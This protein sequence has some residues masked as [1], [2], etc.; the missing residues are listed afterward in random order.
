MDEE[1]R[2]LEKTFSDLSLCLSYVTALYNAGELRGIDAKMFTKFES[3]ISEELDKMH[4]GVSLF[5]NIQY[6]DNPMLSKSSVSFA[7]Y[8]LPFTN[9]Q[10][11]RIERS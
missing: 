10:E 8:C 1:I 4:K 11:F 6:G 9:N 7:L 5:G 2:I 3:K